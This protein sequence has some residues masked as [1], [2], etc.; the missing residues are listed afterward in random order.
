M[1]FKHFFF[2]RNFQYCLEK[3]IFIILARGR[4]IQCTRIFSAC[5]QIS[6]TFF[7]LR[8]LNFKFMI[9]WE[10]HDFFVRNLKKSWFSQKFINLKF[11]VRNLKSACE[12]FFACKK[13]S[14]AL[15]ISPACKNNRKIGSR[16]AIFLIVFPR[17]AAG[18]NIGKIE[19]Q[20]GSVP[21]FYTL[22]RVQ[23]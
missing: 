9:F 18:K 23:K 22:G 5:K 2:A 1:Q 15:Q 14:R 6:R 4:N 21:K 16:S 7:K 11:S 20:G 17:W 19:D 10:I 3:P 12:N 13:Y 8:A